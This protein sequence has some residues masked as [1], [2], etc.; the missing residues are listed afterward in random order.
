M[1]NYRDEFLPDTYYLI[2]NKG[3]NN[4]ILFESGD[5]YKT[6]ILYVIANLL[7]HP[8]LSISAY[9][10]LPKHF[11]LIV[12]NKE[13]GFKLS[14]FM[15]KIQVSYAMYFKKKNAEKVELK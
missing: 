4:N 5:D 9:C 3:F 14:D 8:V 15:R 10:I 7:D 6:F 13:K 1:S 12:K 2:S 11:H